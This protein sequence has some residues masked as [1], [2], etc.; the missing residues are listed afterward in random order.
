MN[1]RQTAADIVDING[2][3]YGEIAV[4]SARRFPIGSPTIDDRHAVAHGL[5][6]LDVVLA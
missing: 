4:D 1:V 2:W 6:A 3:T 5:H